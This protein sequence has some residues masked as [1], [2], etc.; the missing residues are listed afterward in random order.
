MT[1]NLII[2]Y[3]KDVNSSVAFYKTIL[4]HEADQQS[5]GFAMFALPTSLMLGLWKT[6]EVAPSVADAAKPGSME[7]SLPVSSHSEVDVVADAW[8]KSG[9]EIIQQPVDMPFGRT[10]TA[11]DPDGH[12]LRVYCPANA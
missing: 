3:V 9:T 1:P 12:R 11:I 5:D 4:N 2:L 8:A 10:F 7:I 6:Q